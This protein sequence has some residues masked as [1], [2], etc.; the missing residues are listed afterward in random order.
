MKKIILRAM[1]A[2]LTLVLLIPLASCAGGKKKLPDK[3]RLENVY[4]KRSAWTM[5]QNSHSAISR[6][7]RSTAA[8]FTSI[9]RITTTTRKQASLLSLRYFK[10]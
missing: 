6:H 9:R 2:I 5:R 10:S 8:K 1:C 3:Q 7:R 4:T